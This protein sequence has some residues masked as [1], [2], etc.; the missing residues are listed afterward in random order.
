M[1]DMD[2]RKPTRP[3]FW[4]NPED[5]KGEQ[6]SRELLN[7]AEAIF[8]RVVYLTGHLLNDEARAPQILE[9]AVH[10]VW[11]RMQNQS[12]GEPIVSH[13]AYL[14]RAVVR[15]LADIRA[16]ESRLEYG[17][18]TEALGRMGARDEDDWVKTLEREIDVE[19]LLS[20]ADRRT[21]ALYQFWA[22]GDSWKVV[23]KHMGIAS[24]ENARGLFRYGIRKAWERLLSRGG[25]KPPEPEDESDQ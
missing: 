22:A 24:G 9:R 2:E 4:V 6:I 18:P 13:E 19:I 21:R 20:H 17:Y 16:K 10:S 23:A 1:A 5:R 7:A 14:F 3:L 25:P 8:S 15:E 11:E 12:K